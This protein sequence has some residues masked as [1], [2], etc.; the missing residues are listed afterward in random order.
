VLEGQLDING[1]KMP[2]NRSWYIIRMINFW[3]L[4]D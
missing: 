2:K 3:E 4:I 1:I